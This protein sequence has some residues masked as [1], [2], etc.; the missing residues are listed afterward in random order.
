MSFIIRKIVFTKPVSQLSG[1][2]FCKTLDPDRTIDEKNF[3]HISICWLE[4]R[5]L[6]DVSE[7]PQQIQVQVFHFKSFWKLAITDLVLKI[8]FYLRRQEMLDTQWCA[9]HQTALVLSWGEQLIREK[10]CH[11]YDVLDNWGPVKRF[12]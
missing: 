10:L 11:P 6:Q 4:N 1:I 8:N 12:E 7:N 9:A 2:I 5:E 3:V